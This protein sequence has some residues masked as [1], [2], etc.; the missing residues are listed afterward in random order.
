MSLQNYRCVLKAFLS[1][2]FIQKITTPIITLIF[3]LRYYI[4]LLI[5]DLVI[6][7]HTNV[8]I[9]VHTEK[10]GLLLSILYLKCPPK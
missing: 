3:T 9:L 4:N 8:E 1:S 10:G 2:I 5:N 6:T 7:H